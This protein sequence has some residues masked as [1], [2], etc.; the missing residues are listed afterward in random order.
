MGLGEADLNF[1]EA[2]RKR[3][4]FGRPTRTR[5]CAVDAAHLLEL[6]SEASYFTYFTYY[7]VIIKS[8]I[9]SYVHDFITVLTVEIVHLFIYALRAR[10][11]LSPH[12]SSGGL[13]SADATT[14]GESQVSSVATR[15][16]HCIETSA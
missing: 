9:Q 1:P 6:A 7:V 5:P 11:G 3:E 10:V 2:M 4:L 12:S 8:N 16:A 13:A 14:T 15:H